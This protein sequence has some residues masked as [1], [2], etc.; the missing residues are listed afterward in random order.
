M[1]ASMQIEVE[2]LKC[3]GCVRSVLNGL[4]ELPDVANVE[5]DLAQQVVTYVGPENSRALVA[6]KLWSMGYP[7][8]GTLQGLGAGVASAKSFVSCALGRIS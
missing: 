1:T 2:N 3:G 8:K 6:E 4:S 7:E 5:V